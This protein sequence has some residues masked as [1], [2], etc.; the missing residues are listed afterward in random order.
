MK[1]FLIVFFTSMTT[2]AQGTFGPEIEFTSK[3][4]LRG[5]ACEGIR[6]IGTPA[7]AGTAALAAGQYATG[8]D[9]TNTLLTTMAIYTPAAICLSHLFHDPTGKKYLEQIRADYQRTNPEVKIENIISGT[10]K[11]EALRMT[12]PNG[13]VIEFTQDPNVI[14]VKIPKIT[15]KDGRDDIEFF[16]NEIWNR[17]QR[18]GLKI[19]Q[20]DGPWNGGHVHM[21]IK[22]ALGNKPEN[23]K[24][25]VYDHF[26]HGELANGVLGRDALGPESFK[27][28][29]NAR[30]LK[31][32][33]K[34]D[35]I[36]EFG[37]EMDAMAA[38]GEDLDSEKIKDLVKK[39]PDLFQKGGN[40]VLGAN[41]LVI[42]AEYGTVER[43]GP[44]SPKS[45]KELAKTLELFDA[46]AK[47]TNS[48]P[49]VKLPDPKVFQEARTD[50]EKAARFKKYVEESG[51]DY[52]EY[53]DLA[54]PNL[55]VSTAD[56]PSLSREA[57]CLL[58]GLDALGSN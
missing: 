57:S 23:L 2:W 4:Y 9:A 33:E 30:P 48:L 41:E 44:R 29:Y 36:K 28:S 7:S 25:M 53:K 38:R 12:Y 11:K 47:Y 37:D 6:V 16:Q 56:T 55:R 40:R 3:K 14:E 35:R 21:G 24:K 20:T 45:A 52:D 34:Y 49:D 46:R 22:E 1:R 5:Q 26:L 31:I 27:F 32:G 54:P 42:N 43:R 58:R 15:A 17:S 13:R 50:A 19:P 8:Q 10:L 39:Y 51:L 18:V